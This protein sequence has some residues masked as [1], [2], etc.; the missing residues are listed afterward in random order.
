LNSRLIEVKNWPAE[1]EAVNYSIASLSRR[2]DVSPR[3]LERFFLENF[4]ESPNHWFCHARLQH[5]LELLQTGY[6]VKGAALTVGY[7]SVPYFSR[8][9]KRWQGF[10]PSHCRV[11]ANQPPTD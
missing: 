5:A 3:Q 9:F 2:C 8:M 10:P 7:K 11:R 4:G 1:A 6:S